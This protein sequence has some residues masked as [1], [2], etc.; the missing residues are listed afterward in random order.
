MTDIKIQWQATETI[1]DWDQKCI[2]IIET[3]GLPGEKYTTT[4]NVDYMLF[5]FNDAE[6]AMIAKLIVGG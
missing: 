6:D 5:S 3:F 2:R 4:L 1:S